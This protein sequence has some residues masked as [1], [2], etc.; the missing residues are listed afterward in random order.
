M[1]LSAV[2]KAD[3]VKVAPLIELP[4]GQA[5]M[6]A[7]GEYDIAVFNVDGEIV[8]IDD[9]CPHSAGSLNEGAV[10]DGVVQCPLHAWCFDL[11][12]GKM[13]NGTRTVMTFDTRIDD[14]TIFVS[15]EPRPK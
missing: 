14:G 8:A 5:T 6:V 12:T 15:C 1:N 10:T 11:R 2:E 3:F 9:V 13:T 4:P 7:V